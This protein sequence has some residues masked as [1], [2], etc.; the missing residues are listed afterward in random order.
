MKRWAFLG[1]L[2]LAACLAAND[3]GGSDTETLSG[4]VTD[5]NGAAAAG[6]RVKLLPAGYD[7]SRSGPGAIRETVTGAD[8]AFRFG[9]VDPGQA[10]NVIVADAPRA[11]WAFARGLRPGGTAHPLSLGRP[12]VFNFSMHSTTYA[13]RDS[14]IAYFPGTDILA[15]CNGITAATVDSVP[16][17]ALRFVV[18]SRSGWKHDTTLAAVADSVDVHADKEKVICTQ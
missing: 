2:A 1:A 11:T 16:P 12:K 17:G 6:A 3:G 5:A 10:W 4:I 13:Y 7:P 15:R 14:G 8:G 9:G 18:E